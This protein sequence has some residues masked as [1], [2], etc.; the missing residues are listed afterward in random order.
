MNGGAVTPAGIGNQG[1]GLPEFL[2]DSSRNMHYASYK[3]IEDHVSEYPEPICF[4]AGTLLT[5]GEKYDGPEDWND[6]FFC[7][8]TG[9]D[10]GWV[11][12]QIIELLGP[13]TGIALEDYTARELD[14]KQ[15]DIVLGSRIMNGWVWCEDP[16]RS[17]SGWVPLDHLHELA[18]ATEK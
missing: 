18:A 17:E 2:A 14:V 6:W 13:E 12:A 4:P 5:V 10:G 7:H 3:V 15:G 1:V 9:Q 11:P 8:A 16:I